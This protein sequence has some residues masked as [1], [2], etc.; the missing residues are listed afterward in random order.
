[1][2]KIRQLL[3]LGE[4]TVTVIASP[5][6]WPGFDSRTRRHMWVEF[7][8]GS[9]P[10]SKGFFSPGSPAFPPSSKKITLLNSSGS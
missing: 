7:V 1:M 2:W 3:L 8:V 4:V 6:V 10:C 9:C 5:P